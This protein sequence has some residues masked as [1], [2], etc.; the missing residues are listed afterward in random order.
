MGRLIKYSKTENFHRDVTPN[1]FAFIFYLNNVEEEGE[2]EIWGHKH[3]KPSAGKL[4]LFPASWTFS[5]CGKMQIS[6]DKYIITGWLYIN[7]NHYVN[8]RV[9]ELLQNNKTI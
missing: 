2:T 5:H 8:T 1:Y 4:L 9:N 7:Q 6:S 3:I